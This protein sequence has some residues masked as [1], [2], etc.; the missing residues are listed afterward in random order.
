MWQEYQANLLKEEIEK[1]FIPI[2]DN[3]ELHSIVTE[4]LRKSVR[5]LVVE[6]DRNWPW[7]LLPMLVCEAI[8]GEYKCA[9]PAAATIQL[10]MAAGDIFDDIE[11]ADSS[12]SL[13][14]RYGNA[15][16]TNAAT[17][18]LILAEKE[19]T[20]L[21][22]RGVA[23]NIVVSIMDK[24]NSYFT[25]ACIGQHLDLS[26]NLDNPIL[27][28]TYLELIGMKS[29]SQVECACYIG[30]Q[31]A[32]ENQYTIN[33]F[34]KFGHNLGMAAQITNDIQGIINMNDILKHKITFPVIY[35]MNQ[36]ENKM[37]SRLKQALY[38]K[39]KNTS[40]SIVI[41]NLLFDIG[42][43]HYST[44]KSEFYKQ[45]ALYFLSEV[46]D[47]EINIEQLKSYL[48]NNN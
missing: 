31:L 43:I 18:L 29:A 16:A 37:Y 22:E 25:T 39:P 45:N 28:D 6:T 21:K 35:A 4:P 27:E 41:K 2:S 1:L 23:D 36:T 34:A 14:I 8:S 20:Q 32:T 11:D 19:V 38:K 48:I 26:L 9:I 15:V 5:G 7:A 44:L 40:D 13:S 10:L 42:A 47:N 12:E 30:A 3:A 24:I 33:T 17:T 46:E